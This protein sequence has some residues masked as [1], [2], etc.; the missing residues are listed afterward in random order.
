MYTV[1]LSSKGQLILPKEVRQEM[2]WKQGQKFTLRSECGK[3]VLEPVGQ[4]N[5]EWLRWEGFFSGSHAL[6]EMV[7]EHRQEL[8]G[9]QPPS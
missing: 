9:E 6:E 7:E 4:D 1:R 2:G 3:V 8:R 5:A